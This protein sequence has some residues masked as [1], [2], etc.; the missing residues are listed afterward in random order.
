MLFMPMRRNVKFGQHAERENTNRVKASA[1]ST[2]TSGRWANGS[3]I[4]LVPLCRGTAVGVTHMVSDVRLLDVRPSVE[5]VQEVT[6]GCR[7]LVYQN[8]VEVENFTFVGRRTDE[9][10]GSGH[11]GRSHGARSSWSRTC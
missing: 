3:N 2:R 8:R 5:D 4:S 1:G 9:Y 11:H 6:V 7:F 10:G